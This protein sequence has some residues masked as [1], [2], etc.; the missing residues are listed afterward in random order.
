RMDEALTNLN[1]A[2]EKDPSN[3]MFYFA[4]GTILDNKGNME[5]AVADYK[6]S[7]E[8]K[9]DFF[10]ANY[11]LGAAYYNQGAAQLN[12]ANDI[13]PSKVKEYD[14]AR[15]TAL[16]SLKLSLPYLG[17]A[18][19]INPIDEATITSLKTV[20]TLM[21]DAENAGVYKKKLEALPK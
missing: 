14:A 16:E 7:I 17:K 20:Y 3:H 11:N 10:D 15:A 18:H 6:K 13:P 4:R 19:A 9:P 21:G 12:A 2:V 8:L 1:V 5:A